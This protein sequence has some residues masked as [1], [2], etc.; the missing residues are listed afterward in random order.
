M[1]LEQAETLGPFACRQEARCVPQSAQLHPRQ[2][3]LTSWAGGHEA[4]RYDTART[5]FANIARTVPGWSKDS[6]VNGTS[7]TMSTGISEPMSGW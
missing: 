3:S 1:N 5:T 2:P 7:A 4:A 6:P